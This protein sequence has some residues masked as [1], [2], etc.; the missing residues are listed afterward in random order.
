MHIYTYVMNRLQ[1]WPVCKHAT[2][3]TVFK[4]A[5]LLSI[6]QSELVPFRNQDKRFESWLNSLEAGWMVYKQSEQ[7]ESEVQSCRTNNP[8]PEPHESWPNNLLKHTSKVVSQVRPNQ[9]QHVSN[10]AD[11][12]IIQLNGSK[13][14]WNPA[15]TY[16]IFQLA[17]SPT[18]A[19]C[20]R[21]H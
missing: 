15:V 4:W 7:H 12:L 11:Q 2:S 16:Y 1:T 17:C 21:A 9:R 3:I 18:T 20:C 19:S 10:P 8:W 6:I 5:G 14:V 13:L